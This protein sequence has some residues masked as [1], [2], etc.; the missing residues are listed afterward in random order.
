LNCCAGGVTPWGTVL[1]CEE[2][3]NK[4]FTG[5]AF[6][7]AEQRNHE[8]MAIGDE[9]EYAWSRVHARFDVERE[10]H[11]PNRHGWVFEYDPYDPSCEPV[12][13]TALG[14]FKHE[15][16]A[17]TLAPDGRVVVYMG[18]DDE[19]EFVY[20]FVSARAFAPDDPGAN[21]DLLDAGELSVARFDP[22]GT[23]HWLPLVFGAGPLMSENGFASQADV[24]IEARSAATLLGATRMD[25]P[26]DVEANPVTGRVYVML[27]NHGKRAAGRQDAANP[28]AP[29]R[30]GHVLELVPPPTRDGARDHAFAAFRWEIFLVAG[31]PFETPDT[32][33]V[34]ERGA[35]HPAITR[36]GWFTC[37]D[38]A[39]FD[40]QGRLWI[41]TDGG[42]RKGIADGVWATD[43][44][45]PGRAL[46]RRFFRAPVGA[47]VCGPCFT[48]DGA[49]LFVAVQHP[50]EADARG[51]ARGVDFS[52][53][54]SR[55]PDHRADLPARSAVV[56]IRRADGGRIG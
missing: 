36:D 53:P 37:P 40:A 35:Y 39:T 46:T 8:R 51:E 2:N 56:A 1:V 27:T 23:L 11:E 26:E 42:S 54:T 22:D 45:G 10:P 52:N 29:N 32:T 25:R 9:I 15:G 12:K 21:R 18:D 48:P 33:G 17:T 30:H 6:P 31:D 24:L 19:D 20:R 34:T 44:L 13:R 47:E 3:V 28:R 7:P 43:T 41:A 14:R 4:Y 50:G 55:F 16:A 5:R 38:N 49:T